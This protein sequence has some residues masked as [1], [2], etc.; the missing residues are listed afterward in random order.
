[1]WIWRRTAMKI[2]VWIIGMYATASL[3]MADGA[4]I[5]QRCAVCHGEHGEK[6]SLNVSAVIAGWKAEKTIEK[7]NAYRT[8]KL[9][10]YGFGNM[11]S[12]QAVKLTDSQMKDVAAY[13]AKLTPP[14]AEV[15]D[16]GYTDEKLTP[17]QMAYKKF[18][19]EYFVQNPQYG[20]IREAKRL[21][22]EKN[23]PIPMGVK[24]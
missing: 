18:I 2:K 12:G 10:Q 1:M 15:E 23:G 17:E 7:L 11:M 20:N 5:F 9:N 4:E 16:T 21:W 6:Q 24:E 14:K 13:I 3:V 19:R 22:V 8:K